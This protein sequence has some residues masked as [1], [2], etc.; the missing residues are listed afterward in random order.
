MSDQGFKWVA[1]LEALITYLCPFLCTISADA[2]VLCWGQK[3]NKFTVMSSDSVCKHDLLHEP[4][5]GLKIQSRESIRVRCL[6]NF[7]LAAIY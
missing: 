1:L 2:L 5:D 6:F 7:I 4:M 3:S